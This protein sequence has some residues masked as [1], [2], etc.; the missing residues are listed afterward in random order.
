M[1]NNYAPIVYRNLASL[2]SKDLNE[3]AAAMGAEVVGRE[4]N[5]KAFSGQ[6]HMDADGITLNA[7]PE[8]GPLGIILTLYGLNAVPD[9]LQLLPFKAFKEFPD[10]MPYVGA[11]TSHTEQ[12][13]VPVVDGIQLRQDKI[14]DAMNGESGPSDISG[15]T[16]F[17]VRPLP[18]IALCY[19]LYE[20]DEDFPPSVTCLYSNNAN[21]FIPMDGLADVGEYTSRSILEIIR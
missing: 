10:S 9:P 5:F 18:K 4:L 8:T 12:I 11:F 19:I 15:D 3:R 21:R 6:C 7:R 13:L 2:F 17:W 1:K 20:S 16:V 14:L